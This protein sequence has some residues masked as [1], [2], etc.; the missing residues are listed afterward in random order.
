MPPIRTKSA[1]QWY[2][3]SSFIR[4][5]IHITSLR[6]T[7][8]QEWFAAVR[9]FGRRQPIGVCQ[10]LETRHGLPGAQRTQLWKK[11]K[12]GWRWVISLN[13]KYNL[14]VELSVSPPNKDIFG[15]G[16]ANIFW[17]SSTNISSFAISGGTI[18]HSVQWPEACLWAAGKVSLWNTPI[19][20]K[21]KF[22]FQNI[23][24]DRL[25]SPNSVYFGQ[26]SKW[27]SK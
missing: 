21:T 20:L 15:W 12:S 18:A 13:I 9:S 11:T 1:H 6:W 4:S 19:V 7:K 26:T 23:W 14:K 2:L 27:N 24:P 8:C 22:A 3:M 16:S 10:D 5:Y 25:A 17:W